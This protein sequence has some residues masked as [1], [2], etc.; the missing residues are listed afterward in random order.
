MFR[1]E[2]PSTSRKGRRPIRG[3]SV[4]E[5]NLVLSKAPKAELKLDF[6]KVL[7]MEVPRIASGLLLA[8]GKKALV[9]ETPDFDP[10]ALRLPQRYTPHNVGVTILS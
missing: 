6:L 7:S 8:E 5:F 4:V 3:L 1:T 10:F 2:L 9:A